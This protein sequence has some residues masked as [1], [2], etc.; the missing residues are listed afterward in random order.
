M[1]SQHPSHTLMT[2]TLL[3]TAEGENCYELD[4]GRRLQYQHWEGRSWR[5]SRTA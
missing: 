2:S 3:R 5:L 4:S 1:T